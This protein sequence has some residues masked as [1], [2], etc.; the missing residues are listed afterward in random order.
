MSIRRN[1]VSGAR[2]ADD[3]ADERRNEPRE[4]AIRIHRNVP[5][6]IVLLSRNGLIVI[7]FGA[8]KWRARAFRTVLVLP[9]V[10]HA[11]FRKFVLETRTGL[12]DTFY[13]R[14]SE[15]RLRFLC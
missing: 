12:D 13:R 5:K 3:N 14:R 4:N 9:V 8:V 11:P 15:E 6:T 10:E 2:V 1:S 7:S